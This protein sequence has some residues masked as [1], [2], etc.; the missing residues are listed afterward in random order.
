MHMCSHTHVYQI[1]FKAFYGEARTEQGKV[2]KLG[3]CMMA[4]CGVGNY[5]PK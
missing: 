3:N 4:Q 2:V 5:L 1:D